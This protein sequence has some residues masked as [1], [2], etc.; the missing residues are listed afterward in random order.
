VHAAPPVARASSLPNGSTSNTPLPG[1]IRSWAV[2]AF[3]AYFIGFG[4]FAASMDMIEEL[5]QG[6]QEKKGKTAP[7]SQQAV[8]VRG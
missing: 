5:P 4:R 6:F 2:G 8:L 7:W 1:T 3:I